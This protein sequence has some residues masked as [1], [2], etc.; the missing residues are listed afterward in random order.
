VR[1]LTLFNVAFLTFFCAVVSPVAAVTRDIPVVGEAS[2][3]VSLVTGTLGGEPREIVI[4]DQVFSQEIIETGPEAAAKLIFRDGSEFIMGASSRVT[5]DRF[6]YDSE[7]GNGQLVMNMLSGV[8]EFASGLM[9]PTSYDLRT[10]FATLAIRGTRLVVDTERQF[11]YVRSANSSG[12]RSAVD[13]RLQDGSSITRTIDQ[14]VVAGPQGNP[15]LCELATC[16]PPPARDPVTL[17]ENEVDRQVIDLPVLAPRLV[18]AGAD[19]PL[20]VVFGDLSRL[21]LYPG[22]QARIERYSYNREKHAGELSITPVAGTF[23][24]KSGK[25]PPA[26]YH[27]SATAGDVTFRGTC[28]YGSADG[29]FV[30]RCPDLV[31][32]TYKDGQVG[33]LSEGE[34]VSLVGGTL[35]SCS[36]AACNASLNTLS[37]ALQRLAAAEQTQ[38]GNLQPSRDTINF[39]IRNLPSPDSQASP[40]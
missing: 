14:G 37:L 32:V 38:P 30:L 20:V 15:Q 3:I 28:T 11:V 9:R 10:P 34:G 7:T 6:V 23:S 16:P 36:D 39:L 8:F 29:F 27:L 5:L 1:Q 25:M 33:T 26:S 24:F 40:N 4:K 31:T 22:A 18:E 35:T 19:R 21:A 2:T 13:I 17:P 12:V